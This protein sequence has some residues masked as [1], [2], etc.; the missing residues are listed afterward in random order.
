MNNTETLRHCHQ[1]SLQGGKF[2]ASNTS[3]ITHSIH[4]LR[5]SATKH[6]SWQTVLA[7]QFSWLATKNKI[8]FFLVKKK[9]IYM[10][11]LQNEGRRPWCRQSKTTRSRSNSEITAWAGLLSPRIHSS[12]SRLRVVHGQSALKRLVLTSALEHPHA[13]GLVQPAVDWSASL[14][15]YFKKKKRNEINKKSNNTSWDWKY[16][17]CLPATG[18]S[19][20]QSRD[21]L[22]SPF[23]MPALRHGTLRY[24]IMQHRTQVAEIFQICGVGM[25]T[26]STEQLTYKSRR[27]ELLSRTCNCWI[28]TYT[29]ERLLIVNPILI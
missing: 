9:T 8:A 28:T 15:L 1:L 23:D 26:L 13:V 7:T 29:S 3:Q 5:C 20:F 22:D 14:Q 21:T 4:I 19:C 16:L 17:W 24:S 11:V 12:L 25:V 27:C 10:Y 6:F 2:R 18:T